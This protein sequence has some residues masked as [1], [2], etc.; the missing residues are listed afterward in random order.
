MGFAVTVAVM[1]D[2]HRARTAM[3]VGRCLIRKK[4]ESRDAMKMV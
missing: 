1:S 3:G 4:T 2:S